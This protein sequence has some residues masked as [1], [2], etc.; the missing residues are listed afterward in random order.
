MLREPGENYLHFFLKC[1][2]RKQKE[3]KKEQQGVQKIRALNI[4]TIFEE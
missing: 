4:D 3:N 1:V 2:L